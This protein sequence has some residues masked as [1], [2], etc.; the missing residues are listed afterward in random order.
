MNFERIF[1]NF[2]DIFSSRPFRPPI[3]KNPPPKEKD[4]PSKSIKKS[5]S[6]TIRM[7]DQM[8]RESPP[9]TDLMFLTAGKI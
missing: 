6:H 8:H 4:F 3:L 2:F 5:R 9:R 7:Q 1:A